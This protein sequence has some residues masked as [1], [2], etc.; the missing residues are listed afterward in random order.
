MS[1]TSFGRSGICPSGMA[2]TI[3]GTGFVDTTIAM[4]TAILAF[5]TISIHKTFATETT[6]P[7]KNDAATGRAKAE[8]AKEERVSPSSTLLKMSSAQRPTMAVAFS[9]SANRVTPSCGAC[10][11]GGPADSGFLSACREPLPAPKIVASAQPI[12]KIRPEETQTDR[13]R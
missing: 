2:G 13:L 12:L 9:H 8:L 11:E 4:A 6:I 10:D 7:S 5:A 1:S 3:A